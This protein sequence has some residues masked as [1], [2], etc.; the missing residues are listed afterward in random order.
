VGET[1]AVGGRE[2]EGVSV[3]A[4]TRAMSI[5]AARMVG[6]VG[7]RRR[8]AWERPPLWEGGREGERG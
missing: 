7:A 8:R 1:I 3:C 6:E 4:A 5:T 2:G